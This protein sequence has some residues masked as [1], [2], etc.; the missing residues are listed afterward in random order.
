MTTE[1]RE[2]G[3]GNGK[4]FD[5]R[6]R[7]A[8]KEG[9]LATIHKLFEMQRLVDAK[10]VNGRV[11]LHFAAHC[12]TPQ[13]NDAIVALLEAGTDAE[14]RDIKDKKPWHYA[15]EADNAVAAD[16]IY[17]RRCASPLHQ[18]AETGNI[19]SM[20]KLLN[21]GTDIE[22]RDSKGFTP[23]DYAVLAKELESVRFLLS[24]GAKINADSVYDAS[25]LHAAATI[26]VPE[27]LKLLLD[28]G[29]DVNL[30]CCDGATPLIFAIFNGDS[31]AV[32]LLISRGA[33]VNLGCSG[34]YSPLHV[35]ARNASVEIAKMLIEAGAK[36]SNDNPKKQS[37]LHGAAASNN[38]EM[39]NF[40]LDHFS[41]V[42]SENE[43]E[44][45]DEEDAPL[46]S[47]MIGAIEEG[48]ND[49]IM[50]IIENPRNKRWCG[51]VKV[52]HS[53]ANNDPLLFRPY[54]GGAILFCVGNALDEISFLRLV[55]NFLR[56]RGL[57]GFTILAS[58]E[59]PV[60]SMQR[61]MECACLSVEQKTVEIY[62]EK[63]AEYIHY[64]SVPAILRY[65]A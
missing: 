1:N 49:E 47:I 40:L 16:L 61:D 52:R 22:V 38:A 28:Y 31:D 57:A 41:D 29:G 33:D 39:I 25:I 59:S 44:E 11:P 4:S 14:V 62:Q 30:R 51:V 9:D 21:A 34:G 56:C 48:S 8:T 58:C 12:A 42:Q 17:Q 46:V 32:R 15:M 60:G 54:H 36:F 45:E 6:F 18:A 53:P 26:G 19:E 3:R 23:L 5:L 20:K 37:P 27:I 63:E 7:E 43:L 2:I 10:D 50:R 24:H 65:I 55:K 35:A 64:L 13:S